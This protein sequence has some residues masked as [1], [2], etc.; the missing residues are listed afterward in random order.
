MLRETVAAFGVA[1]LLTGC[2]SERPPPSPSRTTL[3][4]IAAPARPARQTCP[5][6]HPPDDGKD[7]GEADQAPVIPR[8]YR[9][10]VSATKTVI[11]VQ[12][13]AGKP[14]CVALSWISEIGE[15]TLSDDKRFLDFDHSGFEA[16]GHQ[17]IDRIS[18]ADVD[19][20]GLPY[21]SVD[22]SRVASAQA[23]PNTQ[24]DFMGVGVWEARRDRIVRLAYIRAEDLPAGQVY[25]IDRWVGSDCIELSSLSS[26][27]NEKLQNE[28]RSHP[29]RAGDIPRLH[30]RFAPIA[31]KWRLEQTRD[32]SPCFRVEALRNPAQRP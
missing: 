24:D 22:R 11:T 31:G 1:S 8:E 12:G 21:F 30:F 26:E 5:E 25:G 23:D 10:I 13:L 19:V 28:W 14:A 3:A 27:D 20:G 2:G 18:G 4:A 6:W 16:S 29:E 32:A 17:V 7:Y 9:D 15:I